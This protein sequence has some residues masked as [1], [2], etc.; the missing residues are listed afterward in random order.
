MLLIF[1]IVIIIIILL[2]LFIKPN[3]SNDVEVV[4]TTNELFSANELP[5]PTTNEVVFKTY[6]INTLLDNVVNVFGLTDYNTEENVL[7]TSILKTGSDIINNMIFFC[8]YAFPKLNI[9]NINTL[10]KD[11]NINLTA[12]Q[13][14]EKHKNDN[15]TK[16][17]DK[18]SFVSLFKIYYLLIFNEDTETEFVNNLRL[19]FIIYLVYENMYINSNLEY[20]TDIDLNDKKYILNYINLQISKDYKT[21]DVISLY[22][23][24]NNNKNIPIEDAKL[25][26]MKNYKECLT[27]ILCKRETIIYKSLF[28]I[29][30]VVKQNIDIINRFFDLGFTIALSVLEDIEVPN[31]LAEIEITR[32]KLKELKL[33]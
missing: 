25:F 18:F 24:T 20:P 7:T 4:P 27:S 17:A 13:I 32:N 16:F 5:T 33:I 15:F 1:I 8:D 3:S 22:M 23:K 19:Y 6:N 30:L 9:D 10:L 26:K 21:N 28:D 11:N 31:I 2:Y 12:Q 29:R 14:F